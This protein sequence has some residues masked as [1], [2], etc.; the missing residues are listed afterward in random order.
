MRG[1]RYFGTERGRA[2]TI[3]LA[4]M[5]MIAPA[6]LFPGTA[7]GQ[8]PARQSFERPSLLGWGDNRD[9]QLGA[10]SGEGPD[11]CGTHASCAGTPFPVQLSAQRDLRAVAGG[12]N[13]ALAVLG[14]GE[15]LAWG[16]NEKGEL[17][18]GTNVRGDAPGAV[19][20]PGGPVPCSKR[21][22]YV[23]AVAAGNEFSLALQWSGR[24][25]AWGD[26]EEGQLGDG[27]TTSSDVPVSVD[28]L[29]GVTEISAGGG[30]ALALLRNGTVVAWGSN[31]DGE[32]GDGQSESEQKSSDVP[33]PVQGLTNVKQISAGG[34]ISMALL[35]NG[36][37]EI[38]GRI[39][40]PNLFPGAENGTAVPE[41]VTTESNTPL[42]GV[43]AISAGN[44]YSLALL[45]NG[46]LDSWG[47]NYYGELGN[48][49][50]EAGPACGFAL[51]CRV[52]PHPTGL[53]DVKAIAA[54]AEGGVALL[55]DGT[56]MDWGQDAFGEIGNGRYVWPRHYHAGYTEATPVA[57]CG[58]GRATAIAA[59]SDFNFA[60][61]VAGRGSPCPDT[62]WLL[63]V[64]PRED[65]HENAAT[66]TL[67][68]DNLAGAT[69]VRI[70]GPS[71]LELPFTVISPIEIQAVLPAN[72]CGRVAVTTPAGETPELGSFEGGPR[73]GQ[74][75]W[76]TEG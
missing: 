51:P 46:T 23:S 47:D 9:G 63:W 65:N 26:D 52:Y 21:L 53:T 74:D 61:G 20:A 50:V 43:S 2:S 15:V 41:V 31:F 59:G 70:Y 75:I 16:E 55:T 68:G 72:A 66:I 10:G 30:H 37:V 28:G 22:N 44:A 54:G 8:M 11:V 25:L 7:A 39:T 48:G 29:R 6:C 24:V 3:A 27:A 33:V 17:G 34:D 58:V 1:R 32:L 69:A 4:A 76:C 36:T 60:Y 64:T 14:D 18:N 73:E 49:E 5:V 35:R 62:P 56:A 67:W 45:A 38:W 42:A 13:H 57:V 19:C 71:E 40:R 12:F